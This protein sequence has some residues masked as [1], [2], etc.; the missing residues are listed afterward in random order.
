MV[1]LVVVEACSPRKPLIFSPMP[2]VLEGDADDVGT[3]DCCAA[4]AD[5]CA[6][7]LEGDAALAAARRLLALVGEVGP[8]FASAFAATFLGERELPFASPGCLGAVTGAAGS[9]AGPFLKTDSGSFRSA[10][11]MA[12]LA[13]AAL[14]GADADGASDGSGV[15]SLE[16]ASK[17][18]LSASALEVEG[19]VEAAETTR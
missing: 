11:E 5:A 10:S 12:S 7:S 13:V 15:L 6:L 18:W 19:I 17:N 3:P 9:A 14:A 2:H 1:A 8:A 16:R 4:R